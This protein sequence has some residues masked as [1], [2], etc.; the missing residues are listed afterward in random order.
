ML[1]VLIESRSLIFRSFL[2]NLPKVFELVCL[3]LVLVLFLLLFRLLL[4]RGPSHLDSALVLGYSSH[5]LL[6]RLL[7]KFFKDFFPLVTF[8]FLLFCESFFELL[9]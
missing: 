1:K 4:L 7:L 9:L 3:V 2:D 8:I 5:T 6:N